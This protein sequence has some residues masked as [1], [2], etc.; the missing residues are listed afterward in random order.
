VIFR[1]ADCE[2]A[3]ENAVAITVKNYQHSSQMPSIEE[4]FCSHGIKRGEI[5]MFRAP[6]ALS[7]VQAC[8]ERGVPVLGIDG[9]IIGETTPQPTM[10]HS[11]DLSDAGTACWE[12]ARQFLNVRI[13]S[14][15]Y[16]EIVADDK[17]LQKAR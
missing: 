15:L 8:L 6:D 9:F 5:Y 14:D 16:F 3:E 11:I 7:L 2:D 13:K 1:K 4:E 10:E 12:Q 17:A